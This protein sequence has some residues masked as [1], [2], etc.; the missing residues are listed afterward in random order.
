VIGT[1]SRGKFDTFAAC[2]ATPV[3]YGDGLQGRIQAL[4]L[5]GVDAALNTVGGTRRST[6]RSASPMTASGSSVSPP[7]AVPARRFPA[8]AGDPAGGPCRDSASART[9]QLAADGRLASLIARPR[10]TRPPASA[11]QARVD[12]GLTSIPDIPICAFTNRSASWTITITLT[13]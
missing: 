10:G 5:G 2:G 3:Q 8:R 6:S 7:S 1:A 9:L 13:R 12:L 4:A 11:G